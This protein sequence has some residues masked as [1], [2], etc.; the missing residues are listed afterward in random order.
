MDS[1]NFELVNVFEDNWK[2]KEVL[3]KGEKIE[4]RT[5][6][7]VNYFYCLMEDADKVEQLAQDNGKEIE[8]NEN[9]IYK[10]IDNKDVIKFSLKYGYFSFVKLV[11]EAGIMLYESDLSQYVKY[12]VDKK[13][14]YGKSRRIF[15]IDIETDMGNNP[16]IPEQEITS[17][18]IYDN[19]SK[20]YYIFSNYEKSDFNI[21]ENVEINIYK[22]EKDMLVNFIDFVSNNHPDILAGWYSNDFDVPYIINRCRFLNVDIELISLADS[23]NKIKCE[24]REGYEGVSWLIN[25]PGIDCL[26][27]IP[28]LLRITAYQRQPSNND[29]MTVSN[30]FLG[31]KYSKILF[32]LKNRKDDFEG[33]LKYNMR[34]VEILKE[35]DEKM[36]IINYAVT[37]QTEITPI[38]L[39]TCTFNSYILEM[40]LKMKYPDLIL[41]DKKTSMK[42]GNNI[43]DLKYNNMKV[44]IKGAFTGKMI[45][46]DGV[47]DFVE[48]DARL[49]K[50]VEVFDFKGMYASIY[51]TFNICF[52]TLEEDGDFCVNDIG[53][54]VML[55]RG[56]VYSKIKEDSVK[57]YFNLQRRGF[58]PQIIDEV[59]S[60]RDKYKKILKTI[61]K[62]TNPHEYQK[63][64]CVEDVLKL[65]GNAF[66][67]VMSYNNFR[68]FNPHIN[69]AITKL[70]R[71]SIVFINR[72]LRMLGFTTL[73]SDTDSCFIWKNNEKINVEELIK[74]TNEKLKE[75]VLKINPNLEKYFCMGLEHAYSFDYFVFGGVKK[76][77]FGMIGDDFIVKGYDIIRRDCPTKVKPM[78]QKLFIML[79]KN[80]KEE[81]KLELKN[82]KKTIKSFSFSDI[83]INLTMTRNTDDYEKSSN[84][85]DGAIYSNKYLGTNFG[86][87]DKVK[88]VF[89]KSTG[90]YPITSVI[91]VDDDTQIPIDFIIDFDKFF[92]YM[93]V[94][95][96]KQLEEVKDFDINYLINNNKT[97]GDFIV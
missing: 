63:N 6:D 20:K 89:I 86:S 96:L 71:D 41:L 57:S 19:F 94:K 50:N 43:I 84:H 29:L 45:E 28:I 10:T 23:K 53:F 55:K 31:E 21:G 26:D 75:F 70:A 88:L 25:I 80:S 60:E 85:V 65:I 82:M 91:C 7:F 78:L 51:S 49:Y 18:C 62:K 64:K 33:F 17:I 58:I 27:L 40:Y 77:Y 83:G 22:N 34:D 79:L 1:S 90:K 9:K 11:K 72:E 52:S 39:E 61:D 14:K 66:Y 47:M 74:T 46:K 54:D 76:R 73:Y 56:N 69:G 87:A 97:L 3:R 35:L 2:F 59:R 44:K 8:K 32:N 4:V 67:G 5:A 37:L 93:F 16:S 13:L 42:L 81:I 15:Y 92:E 38:I 12:I 30:F 24:R 48:P 68:L 95:K 36:G